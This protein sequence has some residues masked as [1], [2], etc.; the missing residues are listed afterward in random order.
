MCDPPPLL[1]P[2]PPLNSSSHI[3]T[4]FARLGDGT[5]KNVAP[6]L[7]TRMS[8]NVQNIAAELRRTQK[9]I[10]SEHDKMLAEQAATKQARRT[11]AEALRKKHKLARRPPPS[12]EPPFVAPPRH[13]LERCSHC[14][15]YNCIGCACMQHVCAPTQSNGSRTTAAISTPPASSVGRNVSGVAQLAV[16]KAQIQKL[17]FW[18]FF[19]PRDRFAHISTNTAQIELKGS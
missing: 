16:P 8:T 13:P 1:L 4:T 15:G 18:A 14:L 19:D 7:Q 6:P 9:I 3:S 10:G 11:D 2:L 12:P 5:K 17:P